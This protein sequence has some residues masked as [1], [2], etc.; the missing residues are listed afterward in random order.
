MLFL[1]VILL[2]LF[3]LLLGTTS[4]FFVF[5]FASIFPLKVKV[6]NETV[7]HRFAVLIPGYKED[8]IIID[9][10]RDALKQSY[11]NG[12][13]DIIVIADSFMSETLD[14]LRELPI[15]L[16]EVSFE[17]STKS[18]ALNRAM[19]IIGDEYDIALVLDAD[20]LMD[21]NCLD[22]INEA[23]GQDTVA[24]QCH[25][26]AKN[27]NTSF[28]ILDGVSE[29]INNGIFRKGH[30]AIGLSSGL[31]GSGM[32]F[33]YDYFKEV[34]SGIEAIGGFDKELELK[35]FQD[36]K[37]IEYLDEVYIYDEKVQ[38]SEV[39]YNQR[40]RWL[41]S[42]GRGFLNYLNG[43]FAQLL[44]GNIDYFDKVFQ[45][46]HPP[47]VIY[48]AALVLISSLVIFFHPDERMALLW[49]G[50]LL[51]G[52]LSLVF[53]TPIKYYNWKTLRAILS[54]P[55]ALFL[56]LK[57]MF[58]LKGSNKQFIH[59]EHTALVIEKGSKTTNSR[60]AS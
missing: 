15:T 54:L 33:R 20:N 5:S 48:L 22:K 12:H 50:M 3:F 51:A 43:A 14:Q 49:S 53:A 28:A 39:F 18:K 46:I 19:H 29:E 34:M 13:F 37:V 11:S 23:F 10:A 58:N 44:K 60:K 40:R 31:I 36:G 24:V 26:I 9:V 38:K 47:R 56:M 7:K 2:L 27:L 52:I 55:M 21:N 30:R 41:S 35:I 32:A 4:Y 42:Q 17:K 59:T 25:R 45:W 1:N 16:I 8:A 57:A 6:R